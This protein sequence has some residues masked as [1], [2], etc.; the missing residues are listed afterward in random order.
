MRLNRSEILLI[1]AAALLVAIAVFAPTVGQP[2]GFHAYAEQRAL[3]GI[4]HA[5]DVLSNLPFAIAGVIGIVTLRRVPLAALPAVQRH[6]ARLFFVGLLVTAAGSSWYHLAPHDPGL[7]IDRLAM[8]VAFAGLLALA[9]AC[10][11]SE[12]AGR[13]LMPALLLCAMA[14]VLQ[15]YVSGN[16]L[17]WVLV[18]VG[19]MLLI[20]CVAVFTAATKPGLDVR[21]AWVLLA[22]LVAKLLEVG[23]QQVFHASGE[24]LSGHTLKHVVAGFAAWPVIAALSALR[25]RQNGAQPVVQAA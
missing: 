25:Q 19:G 10:G 2:A 8:S 21:W 3:W 1:A 9:A 14:A 20:V 15:W 13:V 6:C 12:R 4:P 7:A 22:Y 23:D 17:P 18:Q 11:I 16:V 24:L 5:L